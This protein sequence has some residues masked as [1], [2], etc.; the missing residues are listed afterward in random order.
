MYS[1]ELLLL[2]FPW[3]FFFKWQQFRI[4]V[5]FFPVNKCSRKCFLSKKTSPKHCPGLRSLEQFNLW[6]VKERKKTVSQTPLCTAYTYMMDMDQFSKM[7]HSDLSQS[8]FLNAKI[9]CIH[10]AVVFLH[11]I[12][13]GVQ[14]DMMLCVHVYFCVCLLNID[15][16][17]CLFPIT[18]RRKRFFLLMSE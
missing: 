17:L 14:E 13:T 5:I 3:D 8:Q 16:Q 15:Q 7:F 2:H 1:W 9:L 4:F 10:F 6:I 18:F 11:C 12:C